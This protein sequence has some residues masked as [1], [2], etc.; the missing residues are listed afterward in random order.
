MTIKYLVIAKKSFSN[1]GKKCYIVKILIQSCDALPMISGSVVSKFVDQQTYDN[2]AV[3]FLKSVDKKV[4]FELS[5][6][7][8]YAD[9]HLKIN[10][11]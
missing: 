1:D 7:A 8:N 2:T 6:N 4:S 3:D 10:I 9:V 5:D 11:E